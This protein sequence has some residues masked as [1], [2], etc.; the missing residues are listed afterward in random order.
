M[1]EN[2]IEDIS[3]KLGSMQQT[4]FEDVVCMEAHTEQM[5][6]LLE[7]ES[8]G[9]PRMVGIWGMGGIGKT[10][11]ANYLYQQYAKQFPFQ[12][13]IKDVDKIHKKVGLKG[14]QTQ[15]LRDILR[16]K[17]VRVKDEQHGSTLIQ[18]KLQNLKVFF[19]L[20]GVDRVAQ[21]YAL[22]REAKWFGEGSRIIITTRDKRLLDS[23]V[24]VKKYKVE[25]LGSEESLK[26]FKHFAFTGGV[27][28][29]NAFDEQLAIR[30]SMLAHGLPFALEALGKYFRG[31]TSISQW[32]AD[33]ATFE[34]DPHQS[35]MDIL[36]SSYSDLDQTKKLTF[37]RI[38]CLFNGEH[39]S[40]VSAIL[41]TSVTDL[42]D[43]SLIQMVY[44]CDL[45]CF[46]AN[47][48]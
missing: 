34:R 5:K 24:D 4:S 45:I 35:I 37:R 14:L 2:T 23:I 9:R 39:I 10:T 7:I 25:C 42:A 8:E 33:I 13:F 26:M 18:S 3:S 27:L 6:L 32:E 36:R 12:C 17:R 43:K 30:A 20:D 47:S 29:L 22:A 44:A 38:A 16:S 1:L 48:L 19:V 31:P 41:Q 46:Y 15:F 21:I 28:P 11:I 40:R